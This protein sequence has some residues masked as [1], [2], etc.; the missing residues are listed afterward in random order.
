MKPF[1]A[2]FNGDKVYIDRRE[3]RTNEILTAYL[4]MAVE[5]L[6]EAL[7]EFRSLWRRL[8]LSPYMDY[9]FAEHGYIQVLEIIRDCMAQVDGK[10]RTL[11]PYDRM[12]EGEDKLKKLLEAHEMFFDRG[13]P[14]PI[15]DDWLSDDDVFR[16][17]NCWRSWSHSTAL[18]QKFWSRICSGWRI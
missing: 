16:E 8:M 18:L 3:Y 13:G 1:I 10:W 12:E 11:P 17:R 6:E 4:N 5:G 9:A 2:L 15:L 7:D 14:C